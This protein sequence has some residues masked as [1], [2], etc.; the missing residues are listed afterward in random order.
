MRPLTKLLTIAALVALVG[1][2]RTELIAPLDPALPL[3]FV[4]DDPAA[5]RVAEAHGARVLSC[6]GWMHLVGR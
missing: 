2:G 1:C 4:T 5:A 6:R 3:L